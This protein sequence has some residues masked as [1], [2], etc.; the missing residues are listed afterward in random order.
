[1][2]RHVKICS[3][4]ALKVAKDKHSSLFSPEAVSDEEKNTFKI[5]TSHE[6]SFFIIT[7]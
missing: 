2:I 4:L 3:G 1:M 5:A 6:E 7:R